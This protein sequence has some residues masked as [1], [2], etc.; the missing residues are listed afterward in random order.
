MKLYSRSLQTGIS[1]MCQALMNF[2][3]FISSVFGCELKLISPTHDQF[4][5]SVQCETSDMKVQNDHVWPA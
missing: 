3:N 2:R 1:S 5:M 4:G